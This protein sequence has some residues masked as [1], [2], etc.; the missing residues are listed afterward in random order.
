MKFSLLLFVTGRG[1][2]SRRLLSPCPNLAIFILS[3]WWCASLIFRFFISQKTSL[4]FV[5]VRQRSDHSTTTTVVKKLKLFCQRD[6]NLVKFNPMLWHSWKS[7]CFWHKRTRVQIPAMFSFKSMR[8][9]MGG[10]WPPQLPKISFSITIIFL[11]DKNRFI[12]GHK[13]RFYEQKI[14]TLFSFC[15]FKVRLH[16]Y[17]QFVKWAVLSSALQ[18]TTDNRQ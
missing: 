2:C 5:S 6:S 14:E 13:N 16:T 1:V 8:F 9:K 15:F 11:L 12:Y 7:S 3:H 10:G 18:V 17:L 4:Q